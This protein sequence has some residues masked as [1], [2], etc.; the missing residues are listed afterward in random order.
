MHD[1]TVVELIAALRQGELSSEELTRAC[2]ERVTALDGELNSFITVTQE[3]ALASA[4]AAD[5]RI[6]AGE[7]GP[8]TGIPLSLIH[9]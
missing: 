6:S 9:I 7:G 5:A 3:Q 4:R 2:L 1:K 8:L